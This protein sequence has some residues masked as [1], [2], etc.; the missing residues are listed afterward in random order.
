MPEQKPRSTRKPQAPSPSPSLRHFNSPQV[1]VSRERHD[2]HG[3]R[4]ERAAAER[5][6]D[7]ARSGPTALPAPSIRPPARHQ[8]HRGRPGRLTGRTSP[9]A[10]DGSTHST[11]AASFARPIPV[12]RRRVV[13]HRH[14]RASALLR[15]RNGNALPPRDAVA[16]RHRRR[17]ISDRSLI[18]GGMLGH[19]QHH[20][21]AHD[22]VHLVALEH[23]ETRDSRTRARAPGGAANRARTARLLP[24]SP[25]PRATSR[26]AVEDSTSSPTPS[27]STRPNAGSSSGNATRRP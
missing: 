15:R 5:H 6:Q 14:H 27:R 19:A 20:R 12:E 9:R 24:A 25:L 23:A 1:V 3:V 16:S 10:A 11:R 26:R 17:L 18:T 7:R 8:V 13:D 4:A 22:V 2:R 21:I